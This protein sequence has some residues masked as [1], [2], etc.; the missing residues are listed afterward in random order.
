[1]L[2]KN[3]IEWIQ[4]IVRLCMSELGSEQEKKM[5][6]LELEN[7]YKRFSQESQRT[8]RSVM[9]E[10]FEA[11]DM[12]YLLSVIVQ[13]MNVQ[14]FRSDL[15]D[16]LGRGDFDCFTGAMLSLQVER[17]IKGEYR[18]KRVFLRK[19][20]ERFEKAL[21][22]RYPYLPVEK[23]NKRR[24][25]LV[26]GQ[27][28]SPLH[29]P[30]K[31]IMDISYVLQEYFEYELLVF[32][33]PCDREVQKACWYRAEYER[34]NES[35]EKGAFGIT[36]RDTVIRGYQINMGEW[37]E[38]GYNMMFD[39]IYAW[40]PAFVLNCATV[41]P[42]VEC[43]NSFTTLVSMA[44]SIACPVSEGE[45]LI[46][47]GLTKGARE[48]DEMEREYE[49]EI[50]ENQAQLFIEEAFPVLAE[51]GENNYTREELGLPDEK[52]LIAVVGN[53]LGQEIDSEF[54][55]VMKNILKESA[56]AAFVIIGN[57]EE[58]AQYFGEKEFSGNVYCL[59]FR[60]DL[61]GVYSVLDLYLNPQRSGGGFSSAM[62]LMAGLPV[63]TLPE[64]DVAHSCGE[65]FLVNDYEEMVNI[66]CRYVDDNEFYYGKKECA[67]VYKQT[68]EEL[69]QYVR[70]MVGGITEIIERQE[71]K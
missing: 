42:V 56:N 21:A 53:R 65:E 70:K 38:M 66:V 68:D 16:S 31:M 35:F 18:R 15:L 50:S 59:G 30:S 71:K 3:Q 37:C 22:F 52:F 39:I 27:L 2:E 63:V 8:I 17:N 5:R 12:A 28:L 11:N 34:T 4:D 23:R 69:V 55:K 51:A 46:R 57:S 24:I 40:N 7:T 47:K 60:R 62:A 10:R 48:D 19:N 54:I 49:E 13:Y 14:A 29:A 41:N 45:V 36:Y 43:V 32:L 6:F 61:M 25:I 26:A 1:M 20:V 44:M 9:A 67:L 58:I 64:C 33:C